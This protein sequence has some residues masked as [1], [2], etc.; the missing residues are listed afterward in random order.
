MELFSPKTTEKIEFLMEHFVKPAKNPE[1]SPLGKRSEAEFFEEIIAPME[2]TNT[3]N[4]DNGLTNQEP[5]DAETIQTFY[6]C[7]REYNIKPYSNYEEDFQ[8]LLKKYDPRIHAISPDEQRFYLDQ[9]IESEKTK[10]KEKS[11]G[12]KGDLTSYVIRLSDEFLQK[13]AVKS[14]NAS[15]FK[16]R[17][18]GDRKF[19]Q[20]MQYLDVES[21]FREQAK[22]ANASKGLG[23]IFFGSNRGRQSEDHGRAVRG[24]ALWADPGQVLR[25]EEKYY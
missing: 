1:D 9:F 5:L 19:K 21:I 3:A 12:L 2:P 24:A 13:S 11:G 7:L 18:K 16:A 22:I 17:F 23:N 25:G 8:T 4:G 10:L 14:T 6:R 20:A 15:L